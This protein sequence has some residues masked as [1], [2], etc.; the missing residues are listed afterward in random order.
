MS[1]A[2]W[3]L[4]SAFGAGPAPPLAGTIE[5]HPEECAVL[6]RIISGGQ[7]G[8]DRGALEAALR[9][10]FPCGGWCP[11]GRRAEDGVIPDRFPLREAPSTQYDQRTEWNVRDSDGTLILARG[12]MGTG[13]ILTAQLAARLHRP[14]L[15]VDLD[16]PDGPGEAAAW[17]MAHQ[18]RILNVAGPRE[19]GQHPAI[20]EA[21]FHF[22][23]RLIRAFCDFPPPT[24]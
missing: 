3:A 4:S 12:E 19:D 5:E 23:S 22:V 7:T 18:V 1:R 10:R 16:W 11:A 20:A 24:A 8:V 6:E 21:A 17:I 9:A 14:L 13:T 2:A 15:V